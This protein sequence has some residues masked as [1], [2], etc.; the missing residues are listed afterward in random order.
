LR[1]ASDSGPDGPFG[2]QARHDLLAAGNTPSRDEIPISA[3]ALALPVAKGQPIAGAPAV[4]E[5]V[6]HHPDGDRLAVVL[7]GSI[8]IPWVFTPG[9]PGP[10]ADRQVKV[11]IRFGPGTSAGTVAN[12]ELSPRR[13]PYPDGR[14]D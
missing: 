12:V 9:R 5:A 8:F 4:A 14:H 11:T 7:A 10:I 1:S 6:E 3:L 13:T 2:A